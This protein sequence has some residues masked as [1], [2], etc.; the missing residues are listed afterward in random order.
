MT[1][2]TSTALAIICASALFASP[3]AVAQSS[4][5]I[6]TITVS[7]RAPEVNASGDFY[8]SATVNLRNSGTTELSRGDAG[9]SL[10]LSYDG[11]VVNPDIPI[12]ITLA[13]G[14]SGDFSFTQ[15]VRS[16][17]DSYLFT[18]T[19]NISGTSLTCSDF[20]R[21]TPVPYA[22]VLSVT[23]GDTELYPGQT[24]DFG[25]TQKPKTVRLVVANTGTAPLRF[26]MNTAELP[27]C[28]S[29]SLSGVQTVA[30]KSSLDLDLTFTPSEAGGFTGS[31]TLNLEDGSF[32]I[33]VKGKAIRTGAW[34]ADF[35]EGAIPAGCVAG[36]N[37]KVSKNVERGWYLYNNSVNGAMFISP[38]LEV[39]EGESIRF[40]A[41]FATG[42]YMADTNLK[43]CY[44]ADRVNWTEAAA[45]GQ[46]SMN[47]EKYS[48]DNYKS[49]P[50]EVGDI[51]AGT[52]YVGFVLDNVF[53]DNIEGYT[54]VDVDNDIYIV[55]A[56]IPRTGTV[57]NLA[58]ASV[59]YR[60]LLADNLAEGA[61]A[62]RLHVGDVIA[63]EMATPELESMLLQE[64]EIKFAPVEAGT[65]EAWIEICSDSYSV[66]SAKSEIVVAPETSVSEV[67]VGTVDYINYKIPVNFNQASSVS[68]TL[69]TSDMLSGLNA[70]DKIGSL[71]WKGTSTYNG[72]LSFDIEVYI[73]NTDEGLFKDPESGFFKKD[74]FTPTDDMV[75]AYSGRLTISKTSGSD[76][77]PLISVTL[78]TPF[79]YTGSNLLVTAISSSHSAKTNRIKFE[80]QNSSFHCA[81]AS[82]I[83]GKPMHNNYMPVVYLGVVSTPAVATGKVVDE[84]G[85]A[86]EGAEVTLESASVRYSALTEADG[87]FSIDVVQ[88]M[89]T[90]TLDV[91]R[92]GYVTFTKENV[93]FANG[94][95]DLGQ[96]ELKGATGIDG[97]T[98][99][100][101]VS[102]MPVYDLTGR[103]V[104]DRLDDA[105]LGAGVY[106]VGGRKIVI[107]R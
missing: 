89:Q 17:A 7:D 81:I 26:S 91:R 72:D 23:M 93:T 107:G 30:P 36:D 73:Q 65:F 82:D 80:Y 41:G 87:T 24:V 19:E 51:P 76:Y 84:E 77:V 50:F 60:N 96:I 57:N 14:E 92:T 21:V 46:N 98:G 62:I 34:Y 4:L 90:F 47:P 88:S 97:V 1:R 71:T 85:N 63:A 53:I 6:T 2:P 70:G 59:S 42:M 38:L 99:G 15:K 104:A 49:S 78:D 79:E 12:G 101:D 83:S 9:Y 69:Y 67:Q 56:G 20:Y 27:A 44:S 68:E 33:R 43:V 66:S 40:D 29:S 94:D 100:E 106:I 8:L 5:E 13:P 61:Y 3:Q 48:Y 16:T 105:R 11:T 103:K 58:K 31:V 86:I 54:V 22:P 64:A 45:F 39:K 102:D 55:S 75:K 37:I 35:E 28:V 10:A 25:T 74:A 52:W 95:T 32:L 18:V